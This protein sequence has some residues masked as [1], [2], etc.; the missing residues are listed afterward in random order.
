MVI[1]KDGRQSGYSE[2]NNEYFKPSNTT[3]T[4]TIDGDFASNYTHEL[5][6]FNFNL[7]PNY[8]FE[9]DTDSN[10][11]SVTYPDANGK[12]AVTVSTV[13]ENPAFIRFIPN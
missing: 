12:T 5:Y 3:L 9:K 8:I 6:K 13:T 7:L 11:L 4:F 1:M 10:H 2:R